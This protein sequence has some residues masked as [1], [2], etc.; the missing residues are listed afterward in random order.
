MKESFELLVLDL[1]TLYL[2]MYWAL[3]CA[4]QHQ[5]VQYLLKYLRDVLD[6]TV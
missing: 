3:Y 1:W 2:R 4:L 6:E 5:Y